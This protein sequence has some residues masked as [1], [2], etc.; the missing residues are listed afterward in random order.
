MLSYIYQNSER[1]TTMAYYKR[2]NDGMNATQRYHK[3]CDAITI[4]PRLEDGEKIRSAAV[5]L[6]YE[7]LTKFIIDAVAYYTET[8]RKEE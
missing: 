3:K 5:E 2:P 6:G 7:S 4:R 8:H 1:G